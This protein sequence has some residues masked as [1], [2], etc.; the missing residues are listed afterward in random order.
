MITENTIIV[1]NLQYFN[2]K[3]LFKTCRIDKIIRVNSKEYQNKD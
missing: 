2:V 1:K 3:P